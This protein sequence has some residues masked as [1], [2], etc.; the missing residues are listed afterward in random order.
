MIYYVRVFFVSQKHSYI[1]VEELRRF[2][3]ILR[4]RP[5]CTSKKTFLTTDVTK[6]EPDSRQWHPSESTL[7]LSEVSG[8][9]YFLYVY[10]TECTQL[11]FMDYHII[12]LFYVFIHVSVDFSGAFRLPSQVSFSKGNVHGLRLVNILCSILY[13]HI[14][15]THTQQ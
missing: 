5:F 7:E 1:R 10:L 3:M 4:C 12:L 8:S 13:T 11:R 14:P 9:I 6:K 2:S 15:Y